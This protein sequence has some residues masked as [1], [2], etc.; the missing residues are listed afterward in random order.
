MSRRECNMNPIGN[1]EII[2]LIVKITTISPTNY[3]SNFIALLIATN[4]THLLYLAP[5]YSLEQS[6][7]DI[8][9]NNNLCAFVKTHRTVHNKE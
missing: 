2:H 8:E 7:N 9:N 1:L 4:F 3:N 5:K 6:S